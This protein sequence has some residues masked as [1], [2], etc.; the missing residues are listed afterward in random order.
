ML[1]FEVDVKH[2]ME[3]IREQS[4]IPIE[5]ATIVENMDNFL[6][7]RYSEIHFNTH[8]EK[9]RIL[10][11]GSGMSKEVFEKKLSTI[12]GTTKVAERR[13]A[14]GRYGYGM[15]IILFVSD[16]VRIETKSPDYHGAIRWEIIDGEP[17]WDEISPREKRESDFTLI[18]IQ[19]K[20]EYE[21]KFS[22]GFIKRVLQQYYPTVLRGA[23]VINQYGK[24][25]KVKIFVN[26]EQVNPSELEFERKKP[27]SFK[28]DGEKVS[29]YVKEF[30]SGFLF[31][32]CAAPSIFICC[33][34]V[35][36]NSG[37]KRFFWSG[38]LQ[39]KFPF[40]G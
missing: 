23:P 28:L 18:E 27:I 26:H 5:E 15:K 37:H 39:I 16:Y 38:Y 12:A 7:D 17:Y 32:R 6:D 1:R 34:S 3:D 10:M 22:S 9:L 30:Q 36:L 11:I 33:P 14:L 13:K 24:R 35:F 8:L 25:R 20:E 40:F 31:I 21:E 29:G 2:M 19:L 4:S